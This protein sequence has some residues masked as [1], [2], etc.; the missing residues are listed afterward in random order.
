MM[1]L[2]QY[3]HLQYMHLQKILHLQYGHAVYAICALALCAPAIYMSSLMM[4]LQ[5]DLRISQLKYIAWRTIPGVPFSE[6]NS[7]NVNEGSKILVD[8]L[9]L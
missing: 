6:P 7:F 1:L 5:Y 4:H 8:L 2:V 9:V 3:V